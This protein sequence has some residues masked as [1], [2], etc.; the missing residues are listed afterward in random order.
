VCSSIEL[1]I[2]NPPSGQMCGEYMSRYIASVG[3]AVY[4]PNATSAC[5]FCPITS[6]N[7][8]KAIFIDYSERWWNFGLIWVYI[9]VNIVGCVFIYWL[10]RVPKK[11]GKKQEE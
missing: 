6:T 4:N 5:D 11:I 9:G 3:G 7:T 1:A 2:F 8:L 10:A